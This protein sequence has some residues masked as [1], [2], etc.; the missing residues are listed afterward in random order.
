MHW[1]SVRPYAES[2]ASI[3]VVTALGFVT[4]Q[5]LSPVNINIVYMLGVLVMALRWGRRPATFTAVLSTVVFDFCFVLPHFSFAITDLAYLTTLL[6]FLVVAI[7]TSELASRSRRL[8]LEQTA[9]ARAEARSEA[10]DEILNKISH[11]LRSPLN[12]LLGW[13][14]LL[15]RHEVDG[16]RL[17]KAIGS[18]D[19]SGRLLARLVDDLLTASRVNSGK[20]VVDCHPTMLDPVVAT[21]VTVMTAI[22]QQKGVHVEVEIEAVGPVFADEQR[23]EQITTNLLSN[24]IKFTPSGGRVCVRLHRTGNDAELVVS[25][26]G[27]G[28]PADF[29]PHVFEAFSQADVANAKQGLGLGMSIVKHLVSAHGGTIVVASSGTGQ[30]STF[31][32]R[33]PTIPTEHPSVPA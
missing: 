9:R 10:K 3:A 5:V 12:A 22:A 31:T 24:A 13:T 30:G 14:Q 2:T 21:S 20:L 32:V 1:S 28:I 29:L 26:T 7:A 17:S 11:E 16:G 33:L 15:A 4:A 19:H 27:V 18:I 23:I 8:A 25:D 6:G